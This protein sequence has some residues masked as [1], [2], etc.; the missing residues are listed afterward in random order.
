M[1]AG[2]VEIVEIDGSGKGSQG[3][4]DLS[5]AQGVYDHPFHARMEESLIIARMEESLIIDLVNP[6]LGPSA[7]ISVEM[8]P[9]SAR[10]LVEVVRTA[11]ASGEHAHAT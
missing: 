9:D 3:W 8:S 2:K 4:F 5:R 7:R 1:C 10:R 6:G 11:L